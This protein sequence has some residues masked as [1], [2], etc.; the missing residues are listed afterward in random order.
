MDESTTGSPVVDTG[1]DVS[2]QPSDSITIDQPAANSPDTTT[3]PATTEP[4]ID[5][6]SAWL[7][8]KGIDKSD[9]EWENKL[10]KNA[11]EAEAQM[12]KRSQEAAQLQK[13]L[14]EPIA[15]Q[16]QLYAQPDVNSQLQARIETMEL[17]QS[18]KDFFAADGNATAAGERKALEP[19]MAQIVT[20]NPAI[21]QMVKGGFM[22]YDQLFALAKGSSPDYASTLKQDGGREA[23]QSV[24]DRQQ[25][26]ATQGIATTGA[27]SGDT[28]GDPFLDGFNSLK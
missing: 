21:G 22:S 8:S 17:N 13:A 18:V 4:S 11:R 6:N 16:D 28:A 1:V 24:V 23:L 9:P 27:L 14:T 19:Q 3:T 12:S 7:T 20:E 2:T 15:P 5:D 10:I 25:G 26:R